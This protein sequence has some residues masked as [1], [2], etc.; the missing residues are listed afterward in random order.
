LARRDP[1]SGKKIKKVS[2][3]IMKELHGYDWPGNIRELEH[4]ILRAM[5]LSPGS[6]LVLDEA[7][8]G[9]PTARDSYSGSLNLEEMERAHILSAMERCGWKL[10]GKGNAADRLGLNP[11]PLHS[12]MKKLRIERPQRNS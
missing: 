4:V 2:K 12:R 10:K 11:S 9:A 5:I 1:W 6:T 7:V 8:L 3:R